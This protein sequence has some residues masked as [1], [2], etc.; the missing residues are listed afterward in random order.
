MSD[1]DALYRNLSR[2]VEPAA[3]AEARSNPSESI[4]SATEEAGIVFRLDI[5]RFATDSI[6]MGH[7]V[8]LLV[9]AVIPP[10]SSAGVDIRHLVDLGV[11]EFREG[12]SDPD[13]EILTRNEVGSVMWTS[14]AQ[15]ETV[16]HKLEAEMRRYSNIWL[17]PPAVVS[18]R[19]LRIAIVGLDYFNGFHG[20]G[21]LALPHI[22][23]S[24]ESLPT[25][26]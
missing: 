15:V 17:E 7:Q 21:A 20:R 24:H 25:L 13:R 18:R 8:M 2:M 26:F 9:A 1:E 22:Y 19:P 12:G 10:A 23:I 4:I 11:I 3:L 6:Y 14:K 16:W 5:K